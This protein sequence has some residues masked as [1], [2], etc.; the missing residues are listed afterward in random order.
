MG[1]FL[2][3]VPFSTLDGS[4]QTMLNIFK[5]FNLLAIGTV[6]NGLVSLVTVVLLVPYGIEAVMWGYVIAAAFSFLVWAGMGMWLLVHNVRQFRGHGYW[7]AWR[8]FLP[9]AFHTSVVGSIKGLTGNA[10]LLI[11]G[12]LR[13]VSQVT[14]FRIA[15]SAAT[16][17]TMPTAPV[18]TVIY[19]EMN[20]AWARGNMQRLR[21]L[22]KNYSL[23]S[24]GISAAGWLFFV[25]TARWLVQL[26]YGPRLY[27]RRSSDRHHRGGGRRGMC[28]PLGAARC[29]GSEQAPACDVLLHCRYLAADTAVGPADFPLRCDGR[30]AGLRCG[31]GGQHAA[32]RLLRD[33]APGAVAVV[34]APAR[35]VIRRTPVTVRG[36]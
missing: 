8:R 3:S 10:D 9:F 27:A 29:D 15:R 18:S 16:L 11:L 34:E 7:G 32:D 30:G 33:A 17:I 5:H 19:P 22:I 36:W 35:R 21:E 2:I 14:Y 13:P 23:A 1:I 28:L 24:L 25:F 12:A 6:L 26:F 4:F 20:E 31:R